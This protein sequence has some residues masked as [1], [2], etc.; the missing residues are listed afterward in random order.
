MKTVEAE[1]EK[2]KETKNGKAGQIWKIR[3]RVIGGRKNKV[4]PTAI[5]DP[6]TNKLVVNKDSIKEVTLTYCVDTLTNNTP[7]AGFENYIKEKKQRVQQ[8][9]EKEDGCFESSIETF[10]NNIK[11]FKRSGKKIMIF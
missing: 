3:E 10:W 2:I 4:L 11:K 1:L 5:I 6:K 9:L 8:M 7:E